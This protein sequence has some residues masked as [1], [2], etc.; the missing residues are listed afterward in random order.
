MMLRRGLHTTRRLCRGPPAPR[1]WPKSTTA[2]PSTPQQTLYARTR[3]RTPVSWT[4]LWV[5]GVTAA[6]AVAYY[7]IERERRLEQHLGKVVSSESGGWT[8]RPG[9]L[10]KRKFVQTRYGWYPEDDGFGARECR[11]ELYHITF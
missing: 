6:A 8:P 9:L 5:A 2:S 4:S 1:V 11:L 10:A 3:N 7:R